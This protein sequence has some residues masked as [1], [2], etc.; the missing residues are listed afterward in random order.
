VLP[1]VIN[2]DT[3]LNFV[4]SPYLVE[5]ALVV[6]PNARLTIEPGTV[7]WFRKLGLIVKGELQINGTEA[8]P[9][10]FGSL[11][12]TNWKG[13]FFDKSPAVNKMQYC[14][15]SNAEY[16]LRAS[17]ATI[18]VQN[19]I[20]QNN[21]WGLVLED[22]VVEIH[23]SLIR[24]SSKTGIA[25]RKSQLFVK[26]SV[27]TE[28]STGG[29]ILENSKAQIEQNNI[30]NNGNWAIKVIDSAGNVKAVNNWWGVE[31]PENSQVIGQLAVQPVLEKP[32]DFR[33]RR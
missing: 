21:V 6:L 11:G 14:Q 16:G 19:C 3:V 26:D 10:R 25:A 13:I 24:T 8:E 4:E 15:I 28:N 5:G 32:I 31:D 12:S 2:K 23:N 9:V 33:I 17:T 29:F 30:L 7:I 1:R 20:F 18:N 27:I 22:G